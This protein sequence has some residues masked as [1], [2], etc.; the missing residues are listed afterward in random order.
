LCPLSLENLIGDE[1]QDPDQGCHAPAKD[2]SANPTDLFLNVL[3]DSSDLFHH[4]DP[5][6]RKDFPKTIDLLENSRH[7]RFDCLGSVDIPCSLS[8]AVY[9]KFLHSMFKKFYFSV[10]PPEARENLILESS[11]N[12]FRASAVVIV[13]RIRL[14]HNDLSR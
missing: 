11:K 5:G 3:S 2:P 8:A 6:I 12:I 9:H 13:W 10:D 1:A 7:A 14:C 4:V